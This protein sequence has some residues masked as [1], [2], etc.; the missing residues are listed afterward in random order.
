MHK[1]ARRPGGFTLVEVLVALFVM[2][3]MAALA[4]RGVDGVLRG[5][6]AGRDA[7]DRTVLLATVMS[8]W[9]TDLQSLHQES[10]AT[11]LHFDGRSMRLARKSEG[12]LQ[13][14]V[15]SLDGGKLQRWSSQTTTRL[16][17]VLQAQVLSQQLQGNEPGH[18]QLLDGVST[19]NA[20]RYFAEDNG[21]S[22]FGSNADL[23]EGGRSR[24][25]VAVRVIITLDGK[26]L[27]R[28]IMIGFDS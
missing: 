21:W 25:P 12:G 6:D 8:Q 26:T 11:T 2:A 17:E 1:A 20:L 28:D 18:V 9:Q 16:A 3:L 15:W 23:E 13:L 19:W 7:I 27:T 4:W 14:V 24:M 10:G 22:N 5:R